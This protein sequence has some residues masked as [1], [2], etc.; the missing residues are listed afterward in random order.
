LVQ[1]HR[2]PQRLRA[3]PM[4]MSNVISKKSGEYEIPN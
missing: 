2:F 4:R 3:T 1:A